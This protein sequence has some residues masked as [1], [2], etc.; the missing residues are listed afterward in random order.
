MFKK[1]VVNA[2]YL[3]EL[4]QLNKEKTINV[5]VDDHE[6]LNPIVVGDESDNIISILCPLKG[7]CKQG[8]IDVTNIL[9]A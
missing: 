6:P 8:R 7:D 3:L 2:K 1:T 4:I 9:E 5:Y